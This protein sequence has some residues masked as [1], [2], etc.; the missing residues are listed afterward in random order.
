ME[1]SAI[2]SFVFNSRTILPPEFWLRFISL[3]KCKDPVAVHALVLIKHQL[4]KEFESPVPEL[5]GTQV[6]PGLGESQF[7]E[8]LLNALN[9]PAAAL[10]KKPFDKSIHPEL[11]TPVHHR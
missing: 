4:E 6:T 10:G 1:W 11:L 8:F 7:L 2:W 5:Q 9:R 3:H